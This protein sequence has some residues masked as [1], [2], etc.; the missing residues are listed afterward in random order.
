M[1]RVSAESSESQAYDWLNPADLNVPDLLNLLQ[2]TARFL[3][4]EWPA[5]MELAGINENS[6]VFRGRCPHCGDTATFTTVTNLYVEPDYRDIPVRLIAPAR[7][8]GC[9]K[10]IL[11]I[12]KRDRELGSDYSSWEYEGHYPL[13]K[14]DDS[15]D[16][17]I[18]EN[19]AL[20]FSE[21]LRCQWVRAYNGT[22]EMCRRAVESSCINL[23][24][25]YSKVLQEMIDWLYSKGRIT[26]GL[27]NVAHQ[28]RLGGDRAAHP[29]EDPGLPNKYEP[30][31]VIESDH[32]AAIVEFTRHFLNHVYVIPRRLPTFNFSRPKAKPTT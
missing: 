4:K 2:E 26:E 11:A 15:V 22:A 21:A 16:K 5:E 3:W 23:G 24:A 31:I 7:C 8:V 20:D 28:I 1:L 13:G 9:R 27:K 30:A 29:P 25:P 18:P 14:P 6:F 12:V 32:A 17:E 10:C 19:I